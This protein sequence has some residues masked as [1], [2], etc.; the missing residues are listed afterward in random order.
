MRDLANKLFSHKTA[1]TFADTI[2]AEF[3]QENYGATWCLTDIIRWP[4]RNQ[5]QAILDVLCG[6]GPKGYVASNRYR[7]P[8]RL[9]SV[10][11]KTITRGVVVCAPQ[12]LVY[13]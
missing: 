11:S 9:R 8:I 13:T 4:E 1:S 2:R 10:G 12:C 3:S 6:R 5:R 7:W